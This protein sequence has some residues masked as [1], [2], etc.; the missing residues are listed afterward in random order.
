MSQLRCSMTNRIERP[1]LGKNGLNGFGIAQIDEGHLTEGLIL[2]IAES[3]QIGT[4][5]PC[6]SKMGLEDPSKKAGPAG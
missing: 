5:M 4:I 1:L 2:R 6:L 3:I